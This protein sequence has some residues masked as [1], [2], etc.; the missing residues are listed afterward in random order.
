M[1]KKNL[2]DWKKKIKKLDFLKIEKSS[3]HL[4]KDKLE[5]KEIN[6]NND[7]NKIDEV[8]YCIILYYI[9]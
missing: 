9:N 3:V 8:C 6:K 1:K 2:N 4:I 7:E 5:S